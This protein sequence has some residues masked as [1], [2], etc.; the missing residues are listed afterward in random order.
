MRG[1]VISAVAEVPTARLD[2]SPGAPGCGLSVNEGTAATTSGGFSAESGER[3]LHATKV[4]SKHASSIAQ[5]LR[6]LGI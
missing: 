2:E 6:D 4:K 1:P 5:R 3:R